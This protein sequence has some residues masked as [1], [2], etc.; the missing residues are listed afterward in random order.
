MSATPPC[1]REAIP[2]PVLSLCVI[3]TGVCGA[4]G[5]RIAS[6]VRERPTRPARRV[7]VQIPNSAPL[8]CVILSEAKDLALASARRVGT[9][10]SLRTPERSPSPH[11]NDTELPPRR[12]ADSAL[13]YV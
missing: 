6:R 5:P 12:P 4:E 2:L 11:P 13:P 9:P 3:P 10:I 1:Q 7:R 8:L